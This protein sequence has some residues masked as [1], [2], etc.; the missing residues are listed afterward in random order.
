MKKSINKMQNKSDEQFI[1]MQATIGYNNQ[2]MK[3]N[4]QYYDA[5]MTKFTE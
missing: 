4:K 2:E 3:A 5:K 1:T